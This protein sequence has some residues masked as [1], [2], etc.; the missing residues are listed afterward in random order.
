M[1]GYILPSNDRLKKEDFEKLKHYYCSLCFTLKNKFGNISRFALSYD[2]TFFA[3]LFDS[4]STEE[5]ILSNRLCIKHPLSKTI[6]F[7]NNNALNYAADLNIMLLYFKILD[8]IEDDK[9]F[10]NTFFKYIF[11]PSYKKINNTELKNIFTDNLDILHKYENSNKISTIDIISDPF[12]NLIGEVLSK[13]P[14]NINKDSEITRK[15]LYNFGYN[16]GKWIYLVDALDDLEI[17]M[18]ENK[19]NPINNIYNGYN[20]PYDDFILKIKKTIDFILINILQNLLDLL[21]KIPITKNSELIN[22]IIQYGL[23][24]KYMNIFATL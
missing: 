15:N 13:Y 6:I 2:S 22:N 8:N 16:L 24:E 21:E 1:F 23:L 20:T 3:I 19:F 10:K 12:S 18:K 9:K 11:K 4:I 17:D 7:K 14:F 5:T